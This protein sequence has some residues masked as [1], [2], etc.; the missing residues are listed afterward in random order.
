MYF[1]KFSY[2]EIS[3]HSFPVDV[4]EAGSSSW[5]ELSYYWDV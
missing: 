4:E 2:M 1:Y 3:C 5:A